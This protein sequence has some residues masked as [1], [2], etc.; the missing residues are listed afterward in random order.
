VTTADTTGV[1]AVDSLVVWS[2]AAVAIA[3]GL[4]LLWQIARGVLRGLRRLDEMADDWSGTPAR[5]GVPARLGVLERLDGI[6]RRVQRIEYEVLPNGS[7]SMR[8]AVDR[9]D[10]RTA[11]LTPEGEE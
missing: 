7:S 10:R 9:T 11:R 3:A 5:P 6:D 1:A 4:A 2:V 8:D